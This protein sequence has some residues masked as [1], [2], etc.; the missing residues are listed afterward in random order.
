MKRV[1]WLFFTVL[2]LRGGMVN[3]YAQS[4]SIEV[5]I[6]ESFISPESPGIFQL[7]FNTS[8]NCKSKIIIGDK[9]TVSIS[10]TITD[11]HRMDVDITKFKFDSSTTTF[12]AILT[13]STGKTNESDV[14]EIQLPSLEDK[15][16]DSKSVSWLSCAYG[17]AVYL[18]PNIGAA[19]VYGSNSKLKGYLSISKEFP[20]FSHYSDGY[21]YPR[22]F[23]SAEYS[24][25]PKFEHK[26]YARL[27]FKYLC[28]INFGE[29]VIFGLSG[30]SN[31]NGSNGISPEVS[32]GIIPIRDVFSLYIR[33]RYTTDMRTSSL[34]FSEFS[35]G[36]YSWFFSAHF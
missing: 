19:F 20:L 1:L 11:T 10:D 15:P 30:F 31:F 32:W 35:A 7:M 27:G 28:T 34:H 3:I 6:I 13:D 2:L 5:F 9:Y 8:V 22:S 24:Y 29:Y 14:F 12:K 17:G 18:I 25:L 36:L 33:Y 21:N 4:D 26:N 16:I 23:V